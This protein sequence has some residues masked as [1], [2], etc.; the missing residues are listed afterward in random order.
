MYLHLLMLKA[1]STHRPLEDTGEGDGKIA[2]EVKDTGIR[3]HSAQGHM[4][5]LGDVPAPSLSG[6]ASSVPFWVG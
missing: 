5:S 6:V 4:K 3:T 2:M 1:P